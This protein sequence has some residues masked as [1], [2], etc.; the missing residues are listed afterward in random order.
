MCDLHFQFLKPLCLL[1]G[2]GFELKTSRNLTGPHN[3]S[4][5][6]NNAM[7]SLGCNMSL[8]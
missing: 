7:A 6:E 5:M 1:S 4:N 3:V 8:V 2:T